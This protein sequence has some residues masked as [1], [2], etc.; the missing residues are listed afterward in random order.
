MR[1]LL[2]G[3][4]SVGA[5]PLEEWF[6]ED[7]WQHALG[8]THVLAYD[9]G[10][11]VGHGSVVRRRLCAGD[12]P[13]DT[14]YVEA[15]GVDP[16]LQRTGI[17]SEIMRE[18]AD[19]VRARYELGA[20]GTG[21]PDFYTRL[22]WE[23]WAGATYVQTDAGRERTPDEDGAILILRTP[24]TPPLDLTDALSCDWRAGDVW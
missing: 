12:R 4:F 10:R 22:G 8:G 9:D 1:R 16:A 14:G 11:L 7:D 5:V 18:T 19:I 6:T 17:G 15:V 20:L 21:S 23:V 13:L 2:D 24:R 3:A